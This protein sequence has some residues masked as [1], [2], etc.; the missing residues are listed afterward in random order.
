MFNITNIKAM[1]ESG[2]T[3]EAM[4]ALDDYLSGVGKDNDD[5][6]FLRG[7]ICW[8]RGDSKAAIADYK[9]ALELNP[10]SPAG[11]ALDQLYNIMD[12]FN[13]DIFNP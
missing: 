13:P 3:E 11:I 2:R 1:A 8:Q 6:W 4:A 5:A 12:F 7:R 9:R 10:D